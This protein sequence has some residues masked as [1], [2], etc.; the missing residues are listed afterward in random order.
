[1]PCADVTENLLLTLDAEDRLADYAL[2]KRTCGRA[3]G[4]RTLLADE[5][6]HK[7]AAEVLAI[8]AEEFAATD[9]TLDDAEFVLRLKHLLA[10]Q[11]G[12][13]ALLGLA[14]GGVFDPV[15]VGRVAYGEDGSCTLDAELSVDVLTEQIKSCGKCRGC[16]TIKAK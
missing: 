9:T 10:L 5:V 3:V 12:L 16:G 2:T 11:G 1:M 15:R 8:D 4:E 6:L 7:T 14:P 13:R